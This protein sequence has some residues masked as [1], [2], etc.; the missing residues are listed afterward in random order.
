MVDRWV[1][2]LIP[3]PGYADMVDQVRSHYALPDRG[4]DTPL[5][6]IIAQRPAGQMRVLTNAAELAASL[7]ARSMHTK[8]MHNLLQSCWLSE[9][10]VYGV[11]GVPQFCVL[12]VRNRRGDCDGLLHAEE[13]HHCA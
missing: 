12:F 11:I 10:L 4:F 1:Q 8:V 2:W 3:S 13:C 6:V 9:M 7:E 5:T